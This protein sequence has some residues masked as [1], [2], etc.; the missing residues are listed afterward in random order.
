VD[1]GTIFCYND[2]CSNQRITEKL[3]FV[4]A[5]LSGQEITGQR[6]FW[7]VGRTWVCS[8][9]N[10]SDKNRS[11]QNLSKQNRSDQNC[12]KPESFEPESLKPE[13]F[14]LESFKP[15]LFEPESFGQQLFGQQSFEPESFEQS[16][17]AAARFRNEGLKRKLT[18]RSRTA[19]EAL[20]LLPL[21]L[22]CC[23]LVVAINL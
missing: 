5:E 7:F 20:L 1:K 9:R 8:N 12:L 2:V 19:S 22:P 4:T 23:K 15:E 18:F 6:V 13:L 17:L 21:L 10:R 16:R 11:N 3:E 14:E